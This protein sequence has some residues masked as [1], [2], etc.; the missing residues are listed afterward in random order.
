[1]LDPVLLAMKGF[2]I[3]DRIKLKDAYDIYFLHPELS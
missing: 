3:K 2:A 1:M